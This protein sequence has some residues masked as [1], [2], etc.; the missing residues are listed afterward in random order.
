MNI[1]SV[2]IGNHYDNYAV[3][4]NSGVDFD[5]Q[6]KSVLGKRDRFEY[7]NRFDKLDENNKECYS[8]A[9]RKYQDK[10]GDSSVS[11]QSPTKL[12]PEQA[13]HMVAAHE[14]EHVRNE[15]LNAE[16]NNREIV[17]QSVRLFTA[18]CGECGKAYVSG[19]ETRTVTAS[20]PDYDE[21]FSVGIEDPDAQPGSTFESAA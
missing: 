4:K 18:N 13:A 6:D 2:N 5:N 19:G 7:D 17:S 11:F 20:K 15:K 9:N 3:Y 1:P 16:Q 21:M 14:Q 12:S 10:S 8:C